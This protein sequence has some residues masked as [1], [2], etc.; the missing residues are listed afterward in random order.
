[1]CG[2]TPPSGEGRENGAAG[3]Q[4]EWLW[5]RGE[6]NTT[7]D[8]CHQWRIDRKTLHT[9]TSLFVPAID[10]FWHLPWCSAL[11]TLSCLLC[12]NHNRQI[13]S[14][15]GP[16]TESELFKIGRTCP[17]TP[18]SLL[19]WVQ[20][21]HTSA[22]LITGHKCLQG[23]Y[24]SLEKLPNSS[25]GGV[26]ASLSVQAVGS[27]HANLLC[28]SLSFASNP[29]LLSHHMETSQATFQGRPWKGF[30]RL[31]MT[32]LVAVLENPCYH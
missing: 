25:G 8:V 28:L 27:P 15:K 6:E 30:Q 4:N 19:P 29:L 20:W 32:L 13:K 11:E 26:S 10:R 2:R 21:L 16:K 14:F 24:S 5:S 12:L 9:Q 7:K 1:M 23:S 31:L 22:P 18:V 17:V 3:R